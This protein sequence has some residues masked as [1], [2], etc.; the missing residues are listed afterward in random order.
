MRPFTFFVIVSTALIC[1]LLFVSFAQAEEVLADCIAD[2][3][4]VT[5]VA[6]VFS[7]PMGLGPLSSAVVPALP[8]DRIFNLNNLVDIV[9]I[10]RS[11][12]WSDE[13]PPVAWREVILVY[14]YDDGVYLE[15]RPDWVE[16]TCYLSV[17][18]QE[19]VQIP[20]AA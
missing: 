4:E 5:Q 14:T 18:P 2:A 11:P 13:G 1:T 15:Y 16:A 17:V 8:M 3:D 7:G 6:S 9:G 20:P 19:A 12:D 10:M